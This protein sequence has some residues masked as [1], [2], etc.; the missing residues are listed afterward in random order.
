LTRPYEYTSTERVT[1]GMA[2]QQNQATGRAPRVPASIA[3]IIAAASGIAGAAVTFVAGRSLL[4]DSLGLHPTGKAAELVSAL[5]DA[6]YHTL[7][8][9]A[10][11]AIVVAVILT[12]LAVGVRGG[13]TGVR[14]ALTIFLLISMGVWFLNLRDGGVPGLIRGIDGAAMLFSLSAL[15]FTW[16]PSSASR[17]AAG[18][19]ASQ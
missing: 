13:R 5:V 6:A 17:R 16:L 10:I 12:S 2:R 11:V 14:I 7:Q 8:S 9:R 3:G 4:Q 1:D 19:A 15:L 18:G